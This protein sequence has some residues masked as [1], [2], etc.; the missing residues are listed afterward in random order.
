MEIAVCREGLGMTDPTDSKGAALTSQKDSR[1][2]RWVV[3]ALGAATLMSILIWVVVGE[4]TYGTPRPLPTVERT[5]YEPDEPCRVEAPAVARGPAQNWCQGGIFTLVNVSTDANNFVVLLQ[6]S[7][8]GQR[9]WEDNKFGILNRFRR[10]TDEMV[11][12]T[13]L[14]VAFSLH[15]TDGQMLGGCARKRSASESTCKAR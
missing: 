6:F 8:K 1:S 15:N 5:A 4:L 14:N 3:A 13:D 11:E 12:R 10:I 7:H 9:S 2:V